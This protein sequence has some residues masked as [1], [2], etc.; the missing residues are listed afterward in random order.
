M[1]A[2]GMRAE[3]KSTL[4]A[5]CNRTILRVGSTRI[6]EDSTRMRTGSIRM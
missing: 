5:D 2:A 3:L 1:S 6:C 4:C